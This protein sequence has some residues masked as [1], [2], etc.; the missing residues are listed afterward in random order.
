[1]SSPL[2]TLLLFLTAL[3][4][5]LGLVEGLAHFFAPTRIE[6]RGGGGLHRYHPMLGWSLTPGVDDRITSMGVTYHVHTSRAGLRGPDYEPQKPPGI[7]RAV[8]LGDSFGFGLGVDQDSTLASILDRAV[9]DLEV[10]NLSVSGYSTDQELLAY[11]EIGRSYRPD[12]VLVAYCPNDHLGNNLDRRNGRGRPKPYF[13]LDGDALVLRN[14]P[15]PS[16]DEDG[17]L[18]R[19]LSRSAAYRLLVDRLGGSGGGR[20]GDEEGDAGESLGERLRAGDAAARRRLTLRLVGE[21]AREAA[22]DGAAT[23]L[24]VTP[25]EREVGRATA[26]GPGPWRG[27]LRA[28]ADEDPHLHYFELLDGFRAEASAGPLF[29]DETG[30]WNARGHALAARLLTPTVEALLGKAGAS[31]SK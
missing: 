29:D 20:A 13:E 3:A 15:V 19:T 11:R 18:E 31:T 30:H 16:D 5:A 26:T 12:L 14:C 21:V 9:P 27:R 6:F 22:R 24:F 7:R 8:L 17:W 1:M 23:L 10:V 25:V 28:A 4:V 2:R